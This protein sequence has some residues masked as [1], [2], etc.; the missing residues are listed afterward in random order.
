VDLVRSG[1]NAPDMRVTALGIASLL[2]ME[3]RQLLLGELLSLACFTHGSTEL[4][5]NLVLSIP[6]QW[7]LANIQQR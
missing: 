3:Q 7:L 5:R 2:P 6:C 4:A 1:L